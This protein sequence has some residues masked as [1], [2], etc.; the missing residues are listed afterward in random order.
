MLHICAS[1]RSLTSRF[2]SP[3]LFGCWFCCCCWAKACAARWTEA[4]SKVED[5]CVGVARVTVCGMED[6]LALLEGSDCTSTS[7]E[8]CQVT[9]EGSSRHSYTRRWL[10]EEI[11]ACA[12]HA[13][14]RTCGTETASLHVFNAPV[15]VRSDE[16]QTPRRVLCLSR[17]QA[18]Y[19]QP[20]ATRSTSLTRR[21]SE[22]RGPCKK[23]APTL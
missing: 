6:P 1:S 8:T 2:P 12:R 9:T 15:S 16:G 11:V 21:S 10:S 14:I 3:G 13:N 20:N 22:A 4:P 19:A 7:S 23:F 5:V 18:R 17:R